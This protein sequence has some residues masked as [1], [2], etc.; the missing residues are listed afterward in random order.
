MINARTISAL[1]VG[2]AMAW[3]AVADDPT[4]IYFRPEG[5]PGPGDPMIGPTDDDEDYSGPYQWNLT[6]MNWYDE[7]SG[8]T[9]Q[10]WINGSIAWLVSESPNWAR[11]SVVQIGDDITLAGL[12]TSFFSGTGGGVKLVESLDEQNPVT[13]TFID[14]SSINGGGGADTRRLDLNN[15]NLSGDITIDGRTML[16]NIGDFD[17][18]TLTVTE[19][20]GLRDSSPAA[21]VI[22]DNGALKTF[23]GSFTMAYLSGNGFLNRASGVSGI[24]QWMTLDQP[25]NTVVTGGFVNDDLS[26]EMAG[27]GAFIVNNN[28]VNQN[29]IRNLTASGGT[30][31]LQDEGDGESTYV[32]HD[33][34]IEEN[35]EFGGA[36]RIRANQNFT[37]EGADSILTAGSG[38]I[39]GAGNL[40][41]RAGL[42]TIDL[43][44]A[45]SSKLEAEDGGTFNFY[46]DDDDGQGVLVNSRIDFIGDGE[47][48]LGGTKTVNLYGLGA[49]LIQTGVAYTLISI[50]GD[51]V[52]AA[53][54][55]DGWEI[56][57][58]TTG[59]AVDSFGWNSDNLTVTLIPEP[60]TMMLLLGGLTTLWWVRKRHG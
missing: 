48:T 39:D 58:N 8:G 50:G 59:Y 5:D 31:L 34:T 17:G 13:L 22:L 52:K 7:A 57:D 41:R 51:V 35:A 55:D 47:L 14:G 43:E 25:E 60:G 1:I 56:G 27:S 44:N 40:T 19:T 20:L 28:R 16:K 29:E 24:R 36:T 6:E 4:T 26:F 30:F 18:G 3:T 54:W 2:A 11:G 42:L 49:D 53:G 12:S 45:S 32:H 23:G 37:L 38:T 10:Q 33:I 9:A 15:V 21:R 46:L